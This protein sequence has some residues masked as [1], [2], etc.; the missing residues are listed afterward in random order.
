MD[1][2]CKAKGSAMVWCTAK[3]VSV[4]CLLMLN[5]GNCS[6]KHAMRTIEEGI[7][8]PAATAFL[9]INLS[10]TISY[11]FMSWHILLSYFRI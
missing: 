4:Q 6:N 2:W 1:L 11:Y 9:D 5:M 10:C 8:H 7:E 3:G